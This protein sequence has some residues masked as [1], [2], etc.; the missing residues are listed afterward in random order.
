[1]RYASIGLGV[2]QS[3]ARLGA[4]IWVFARVGSLT[5]IGTNITGFDSSMR[6]R[7]ENADVIGFNSSVN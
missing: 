7:V 1:M 5:V 3:S 2:L 6:P 4:N